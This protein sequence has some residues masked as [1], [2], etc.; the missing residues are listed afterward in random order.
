MRVGLAWE[1]RHP[2]TGNHIA[3]HFQASPARYLPHPCRRTAACFDRTT[4]P[5]DQWSLLPLP[6]IARRKNC[7]RPYQ[8]QAVKYPL[9]LPLRQKASLEFARVFPLTEPKS[10]PRPSGGCGEDTREQ[11]AS[12]H[13]GSD[14]RHAGAIAS[15]SRANRHAPTWRIVPEGRSL[16]HLLLLR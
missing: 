7:F 5:S 4:L 10:V 2:P 16:R 3:P 12:A 11:R 1:F 8:S 9:V 14:A 6:K 15:G 13:N